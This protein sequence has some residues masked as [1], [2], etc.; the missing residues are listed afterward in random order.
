M[1]SVLI[2][3]YS[4][5]IVFTI[6][7]GITYS[8]THDYASYGIRMA[9]TDYFVVLA[10]NDAFQY[11]VSMTPFGSEY[12]CNYTYSTS[13]EFVINVAVG[14]RQNASQLSFV[15][16]RTNSTDGYYQTL[17]L[18]TFSRMNNGTLSKDICNQVNNFNES[19]LDVKVWNRTPSELSLLQVDLNGNYAY[20]FLSKAIFI[21]DIQNHFVQD[22]E[23]E[24][25]FPSMSIE[26][27]ALEIG[28][29]NDGISIAIVAGYRLLD[30]R[31]AVP[32]VYL[33]HLNPPYNMTLIDNYTFLSTKQKFLP[34]N[35]MYQSDYAMSVSIHDSTQQVLVSVSQLSKTYMFSYNSTALKLIQK[36]D[37]SARSITWLDKDGLQAGFLLHNVP[38]YPWA[39]SR[40][41]IVNMSSNVV[42]NVFPNNQ[43]TIELWSSTLPTFIRMG[44]T[45]DYQLVI[46]T[47]DGTVIFVR[48]ADAGYYA[49][50]GD[51]DSDLQRQQV[52][53]SGSYKSIRGSI[54][55]TICPTMTRSNPTKV[56]FNSSNTAMMIEYP[57][58]NCIACS[59]ASFCPLASISDM[60][61]S[62]IQSISQ[63]YAYPTSSV[64]P[65]F[66]DILM[67]N[68]FTLQSTPRRCLLISPLFW[69]LIALLFAFIVLI[70]MGI[71]Y[72][73][74]T[75]KKYVHRLQCLFRHSDLIGNGELWLGGLVSFSV[76][77][78][79]IY[80]FWFGSVFANVYPIEQAS[81]AYFSCDTTLLNAQFT[82]SLQL[83]ATI[84]S[85]E[86]ALM[87]KML[88]QQE[89]IMTVDFLQTSFTCDDITTQENVGTY[90]VT[91]EY[92][93]CTVHENNA[94]LSISYHVP[95]HQTT[96]QINLT[97]LYY[98][99]GV[100][101]C[102][103]GPRMTSND[104]TYIVQKMNYCELFSSSD[105][106]LGEST[107]I[108][109]SLTKVIN[110]TETLD[111]G[112]IVNYT[113]IW[114]PTSSHG[115]LNDRVAYAKRGAF[116]RYLSTQQ[117]LIINFQE[118]PFYV[119]NKQE[120]I[121]RVGEIL[122][123]NVLFTTTVI[124]IFTLVFLVLKLTFMP[125]GMWIIKHELFLAQ[126]LKLRDKLKIRNDNKL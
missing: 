114:I 11:V 2:I 93:N 31:E 110:R 74:P 96:L 71:L 86:E 82:S 56:L 17:G 16:L 107:E 91:F 111:Y 29:T 35:Y 59:S 61:A 27:Y 37:R 28:E 77:L 76:I 45:Y 53:P 3:V 60:N 44:I 94:T 99:G 118:T 69:S 80:G 66:D 38:T 98:I 40:I 12:F 106:T 22:L 52:C 120:P 100:Y 63:A 1:Y 119:M 84:K 122:F 115:A 116:L 9:S 43:Q 68:T 108:E 112:S 7:N 75:S 95:D 87:F 51:I 58:I 26:P 18:F 89:F 97:D 19:R 126:L 90:S 125:I 104:S 34:T 85:D 123:H 49:T 117:T 39:Q 41:E 50:T 24:D 72:C 47:T 70:I 81:A 20:G 42:L 46:L 103:T 54:P 105:Q 32:V 65:S 102:L 55:C 121:A 88:D 48:A 10:Q 109:F 92:D 57:T 64:N 78:L 25:M 113:G 21:Y 79:V 13:N 67:Q 62:T 8:D 124:G 73:L 5:M 6:V 30:I 101:I 83:L 15:Y 23:W 36:F 33:I 4:F 14:R